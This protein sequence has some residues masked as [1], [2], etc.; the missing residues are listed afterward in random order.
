MATVEEALKAAGLEL[1]ELPDWETR[2]PIN[3]LWIAPSF[4]KWFDETPE[5]DDPKLK[6]GSRTLAEHIEQLFCE[7]R[8]S[9]R[10]GGGDLRRMM[11]NAKGIWK[12]HPEKLASMDGLQKRDVWPSYQARWRTKRKIRRRGM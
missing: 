11:P 3:Q 5:L 8:C 9:E 7:L 10:L 4:W 12:F 2:L 1:Y 6:S